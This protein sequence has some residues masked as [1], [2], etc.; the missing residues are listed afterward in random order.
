MKNNSETIGNFFDEKG[1]DFELQRPKYFRSLRS[2]YIR[3]EI[4]GNDILDIGCHYGHLAKLYISNQNFVGLDLSMKGLNY[5]K[6]LIGKGIYLHAKAQELPFQDESFDTI[7]CSEVI[8]YLDEPIETLKKCRAILKK[9]G[10]IIVVCSNKFHAYLGGTIGTFLKM[11]PK[12]INQTCYYQKDI[13]IFLKN[14]GF[15][16]ITSKGFGVLPFKWS[17]FLDK[18]PLSKIGFL[19]ITTAY[20]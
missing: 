10:K 14:S 17:K 1:I 15:E 19:H 5:A 4:R 20:R 9:R 6:K 12:D 13:K 8:Y 3:K 2:E 18:T 7:V 16:D 11:K